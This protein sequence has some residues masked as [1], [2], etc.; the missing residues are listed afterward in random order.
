MLFE[1]IAST[2]TDGIPFKI[3]RARSVDDLN[4]GVARREVGQE[5]VATTSPFVRPGN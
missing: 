2:T 5:L 4:Q 1:W 3:S